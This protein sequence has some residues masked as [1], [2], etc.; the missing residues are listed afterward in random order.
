MNRAFTGV[1]FFD[2]P[3]ANNR[4]EYWIRYHGVLWTAISA[5][6]LSL[7]TGE[8]VKVVG[9]QGNRLIIEAFS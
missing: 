1:G 5:T 6:P 2:E 4:Q 8:K 3:K 9:R 7:K